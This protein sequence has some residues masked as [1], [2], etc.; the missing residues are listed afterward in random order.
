MKTLLSLR[1]KARELYSD[2]YIQKEW[3]RAIAVVRKT[4]NGWHLDKSCSKK[5]TKRRKIT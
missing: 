5:T 3:L 1:H 4:K 2:P